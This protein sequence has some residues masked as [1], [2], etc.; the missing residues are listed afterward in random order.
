MSISDHQDGWQ[1]ELDPWVGH[2]VLH[3]FARGNTNIMEGGKD[4]DKDHDGCVD[5]VS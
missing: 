4:C 3:L 1:C 5:D 2:W